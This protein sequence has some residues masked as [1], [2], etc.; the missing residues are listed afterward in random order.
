ME[1]LTYLDHHYGSVF[2]WF[3]LTGHNVYIH[4]QRLRYLLQQYRSHKA[5]CFGNL[6]TMD[7]M[8]KKQLGVFQTKDY[9]KERPGLV[10]SHTT[11]HRLAK[12][13]SLCLQHSSISNVGHIFE[14]GRCIVNE[15][16]VDCFH[17]LSKKVSSIFK[18][19]VRFFPFY[20]MIHNEFRPF[21][22]L[23][24]LKER[25][26][27]SILPIKRSFPVA[28]VILLCSLSLSLSGW[29]GLL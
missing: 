24:F 21:K 13:A 4:I 12:E 29:T 15:L 19:D 20:F 11:V 25:R 1:I 23:P 17:S 9:T 16:N 6:W 26:D 22:P 2:D 28:V 7:K 8:T 27:N 5:L 18:T 14:I 3:V 10:M